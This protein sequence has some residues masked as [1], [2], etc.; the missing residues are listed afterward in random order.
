MSQVDLNETILNKR[1]RGRPRKYFT[2]EEA[3][4]KWRENVIKNN[5]NNAEQLRQQNKENYIRKT[6]IENQS[7]RKY[8]TVYSQMYGTA[9]ITI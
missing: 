4:E 9:G 2:E 6:Y 3:K 5:K 1:G 8:N 7:P